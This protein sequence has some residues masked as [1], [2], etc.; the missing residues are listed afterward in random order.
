MVY[1]RNC[2]WNIESPLTSP[3]NFLTK[4]WTPATFLKS[5]FFYAYGNTRM[6]DVLQDFKLPEHV[7]VLFLG[8]GDIRHTLKTIAGLA[9]R[10]KSASLSKSVN[11]NLVDIDVE[12]IARDVVLWEI[13]NRIDETNKV[14][15]EFLWEIWFNFSLTKAHYQRLLT[16]LTEICEERYLSP[17]IWGFGD[18]ASK[19]SV[20]ETLQFWLNVTPWNL[21][22][23]SRSRKKLL[24]HYGNCNIDDPSDVGQ[25]VSVLLSKLP[26][27]KDS[28]NTFKSEKE[29]RYMA[30]I[31]NSFATGIHDDPNQTTSEQKREYVNPT[32]MRPNSNEWHVHYDSKAIYCFLPM[33]ENKLDGFESLY[34]ACISDLQNVIQSYRDSLN[35]LKINVSVV[36]WAHDA[37]Y[38][39]HQQLQTG[40]VFDFIHTSNL[41]D[42]V[43]LLNLLATCGQLL[44]N[45]S[46]VLFTESFRWSANH[47]S[48]HEFVCANVGCDPMLFPLVLGL[49][50]AENFD[51]GTSNYRSPTMLKSATPESL[52]WVK[53][54][55]QSNLLV[56]LEESPDVQTFLERLVSICCK[57]NLADMFSKIDGSSMLTPLTLIHVLSGMQNEIA[58]GMEVLLQFVDNRLNN[59]VSSLHHIYSWNALC[60]ALGLKSSIDEL[61]VLQFHF[62]Y[63]FPVCGSD[64]KAIGYSSPTR[65]LI[66]DT[67]TMHSSSKLDFADLLKHHQKIEVISNFYFDKRDH[68]F[69]VPILMSSFEK[70]SD[71]AFITL[72]L[73]DDMDQKPML[74]VKANAKIVETFNDKGASLIPKRSN[75]QM[76]SLPVCCEEFNDRYDIELKINNEGKKMNCTSEYFSALGH[77]FKT[78]MKIDLEYGLQEKQ[79]FSLIFTCALNV[80]KVKLSVN[81]KKGFIR[82][83]LLKCEKNVGRYLLPLR[84]INDCEL[85][86]FRNT[87]EIINHW[88]SRN[89]H[90]IM[91]QSVTDVELKFKSMGTGMKVMDP[92]FCLRDTIHDIWKTVET[93]P[94]ATTFTYRFEGNDS[95]SGVNGKL[96]LIIR[97]YYLYQGMPFLRV[98]FVDTEKALRMVDEKK[99]PFPA[100]LAKRLEAADL[101]QWTC[102]PDFDITKTMEA[103]ITKAEHILTKKLLLTNSR[104]CQQKHLDTESKGWYWETFLQL[105][106]IRDA[107]A[108]TEFNRVDHPALLQNVQSIDQPTTSRSVDS[109]SPQSVCRACG[110]RGSNFKRCGRCKS[111]SYCSKECQIQNWITHKKQCKEAIADS[112]NTY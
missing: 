16:I 4:C 97:G 100:L 93:N 88:R 68:T 26:F 23:V 24:K 9:C 83:V 47:R 70:L 78:G 33:E 22:E 21:E 14:D 67:P 71:N 85:T 49:H 64:H 13:I 32:L 15:I 69:S 105:L 40:L 35:K 37:F 58:G 19:K 92:F 99:L 1:N 72:L 39:L 29:Q 87:K 25:H 41:T 106:F 74:N 94:R 28:F 110:E 108:V 11:F 91:F 20:T 52:F 60:W 89:I 54:N 109:Q 43:G 102:P 46:S 82:G 96:D 42:H 5:R 63:E 61:I 66:M 44:R 86:S 79:N 90:D 31:A 53:S 34:E 17:C 2:S 51:L 38:F 8:A 6:E 101:N 62:D 95:P 55:S 77:D 107:R 7:D 81:S 57:D 111:A 76:R 45:Q 50:L 30:E 10:P 18:D 112:K 59:K 12:V 73:T 75:K 48:L 98:T 104:R 103:N 65:L 3:L 84:L 36:M 56:S 27:Y 80:E